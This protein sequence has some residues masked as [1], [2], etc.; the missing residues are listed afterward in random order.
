MSQDSEQCFRGW[1]GWPALELVKGV[2]LTPT[3][4]GAS[5]HY[6]TLD[7]STLHSGEG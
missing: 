2:K 4:A 6:Q 7:T 3:P 1:G 5:S